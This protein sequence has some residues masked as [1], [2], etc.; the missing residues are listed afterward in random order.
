MKCELQTFAW[1]IFLYFWYFKRFWDFIKFQRPFISCN[2]SMTTSEVISFVQFLLAIIAYICTLLHLIVGESNCKFSIFLQVQLNPPPLLPP[3]HPKPTISHKKYICIY[4]CDECSI[5]PV[6]CRL[7][8]RTLDPSHA[9]EFLNDFLNHQL[10][11]R[12]TGGK[13]KQS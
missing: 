12:V 11:C 2:L 6:E 1:V 7:N 10:T 4:V 9:H 3:L 13:Q 8:F 5:F